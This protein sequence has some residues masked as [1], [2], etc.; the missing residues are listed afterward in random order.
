[1]SQKTT[2]P[3]VRYYPEKAVS[4]MTGIDGTLQ[5]FAHA[6]AVLEDGWT[7][8]DIGAGRGA[9]HR[10]DK[11]RFRREL[12]RF[13]G[14][15]GRVIGLD[16]DE[17]VA[18]NP[19]LDEWHL[20]GSD[21]KLP[22]GDASVDMVLSD[23]TFE[24]IPDPALFAA[25]IARILRPGGWLCARTPNKWGYVSLG[26]RIVPER[27]HGR[28]LARL[29]PGRKAEDIFP[30]HYLLNTRAALARHFPDED[31]DRHVQM[32]SPEPAYCGNRRWLWAI[33]RFVQAVLPRG[34]ATTIHF[35]AR[36]RG[37]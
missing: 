20:I 34:M 7:V 27:L 5:F 2:D 26:A 12:R 13:N 22:L 9:A 29:Q 33:A 23:F 4:G 25:E 32:W 17:A 1:M 14:R 24:H 21:G 6:N 35:Y 10:D 36:K 3:A 30:T 37:A 16:V 18:T 19:V 31:W 11:V 15:A 8:C 28:L